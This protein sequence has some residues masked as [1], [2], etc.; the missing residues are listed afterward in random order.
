MGDKYLSGRT[1]SQGPFFAASL[2]VEKRNEKFEIIIFPAIPSTNHNLFYD[3]VI[4][5]RSEA[6]L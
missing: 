5:F 4:G 3:S 6:P 2:S 1:T